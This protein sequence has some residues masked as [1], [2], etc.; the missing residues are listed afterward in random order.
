MPDEVRIFQSLFVYDGGDLIRLTRNHRSPLG[1]K[2]G[3]INPQGYMVTRVNGKVIA[4]HRIIFTM[5]NG[6]SPENHIDHIN[7]NKLDNRI[8]NLREVSHKCNLRNTGNRSNNTS[9]VKGVRRGAKGIWDAVIT[10]NGKS[11][12]LGQCTDFLEAV[13]HRLAGEQALNWQGCDSNSPAYKYV[14]ENIR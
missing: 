10:N 14:Q 1:S 9:G 11:I 12:R 7:K 8:E 4:N 5:L 2:A 6:Y 13:C 3:T